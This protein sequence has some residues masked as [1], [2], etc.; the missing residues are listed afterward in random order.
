M[1]QMRPTLEDGLQA[2]REATELA[3]TIRIDLDDDYLANIA[4]VEARPEN[5]S[6]ADKSWVWRMEIAFQHFY[7]A[8][9]R[10]T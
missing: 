8:A 7:A 6:G 1:N 9:R 5:Q 4:R 3:K 10:L 2:L